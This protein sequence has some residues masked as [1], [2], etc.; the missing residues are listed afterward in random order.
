MKSIK[1]PLY[2]F[3]KIEK[4]FI[5]IIDTR[6]FQRLRWI[7]QLGLA[8]LVYPSAIHSRFEHSIGCFYLACKICEAFEIDTP[9]F[10]AAALLHDIGHL[11][12]SHAVE[13][14]TERHEKLSVKKIE[15]SRI[16]EILEKGGMN[17]KLVCKLIRG[18][19]KLGKLISGEIDVD[20]LDYLRRDAYYTGVAYGVIDSDAVIRGLNK[21]SKRLWI[22]FDYVPAY[23]SL[24]IAR[25][26]MYPTVYLH[27]TVRCLNALLRRA[28]QEMLKR[29][30]IKIE[31][32]TDGE[33][34]ECL[35]KSEASKRLVERILYRELYKEIGRIFLSEK[36][37]NKLHSPWVCSEI[38]DELAER[39]SLK[40]G[41]VLIHAPKISEFSESKVIV[42]E[43]KKP[44]EEVSPLVRALNQALKNYMWLGVYARKSVSRKVV[45]KLLER[46]L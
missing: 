36:Q 13:C 10:K 32:F 27:H 6:E 19:N 16:A 20:R 37:L 4:P 31:N 35:K 9:E 34:L 38:E 15:N 3:V 40:K 18:K 44:L 30:E 12:F 7:R 26:L 43:I 2:G 45:E 42:S 5:E 21:I 39:F 46:F 17:V 41:D 14:L 22:K 1:D 24:L 28:C 29:E 11:P 33:L 25:Y 8:Q 23:E